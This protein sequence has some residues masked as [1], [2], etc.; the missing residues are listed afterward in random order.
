M[1]AAVAHRFPDRVAIGLDYRRTA[2]GRDEVASHGWEAG[3]GR[4]VTEVLDLLAEAPVAAFI[5]TAIE[6][7]G[8]LNGPDLEGLSRV[9]DATRH[10]VIASGGVSN[11]RDL[12]ELAGLRSAEGRGLLGAITGKAL[13]DGRLTVSEGIAACTPSV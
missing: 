6:R 3:S 5:V 10:E 13:V 7:D 8:M 12:V 4:T 11:A 1:A 2:D 9:L